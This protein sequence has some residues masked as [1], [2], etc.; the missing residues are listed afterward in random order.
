MGQLLYD[1]ASFSGGVLAV[2]R[3]SRNAFRSIKKSG[4]C[5][6]LVAAVGSASWKETFGN[7]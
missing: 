7:F 3:F 4:V 6:R 2:L 5:S 1:G